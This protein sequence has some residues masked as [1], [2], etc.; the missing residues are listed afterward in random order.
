MQLWLQEHELGLAATQI[1]ALVEILEVAVA[2]N[3]L[4]PSQVPALP[5]CSLPT[6][7]AHAACSCS[8]TTLPAAGHAGDELSHW[9]RQ[10]VTR[11]TELVASACMLERLVPLFRQCRS[12]QCSA[13]SRASGQKGDAQR[14][15]TRVAPEDGGHCSDTQPALQVAAVFHCFKGLL[16]GG[17]SRRAERDKRRNSED[18]DDEEAE[19]MEVLPCCCL[20]FNKPCLSWAPRCPSPACCPALTPGYALLLEGSRLPPCPSTLM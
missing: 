7:T 2:D 19:K 1:E 12:Q 14:M 11:T 17:K 13:A 15:Q 10:A 9:R 18:F 16:A 5:C 3:L 20:D 8:T 4:Q 6:G